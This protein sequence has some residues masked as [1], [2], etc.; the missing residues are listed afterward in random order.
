[1][2]TWV[3]LSLFAKGLTTGEISAHFEKISKASI[4]KDRIS[5]IT[6][7]VIDEMNEW[8]SR[9]PLP[10]YAAVSIDAIHA[11][12]R[13]GQVANRAFYAVIG[14]DLDGHRDVLGIWTGTDGRG[15]SAKYWMSVLTK[16]KTRGVADVLFIVGDGLKGILDSASAVF[17]LATIQTCTI[18]VIR[19]TFCATFADRM[20]AA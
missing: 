18:H 17:P 13:D 11:K 20:T 8:C 4:S 10:V 7:A 6:D 5:K 14:V 19:G 2:S 3:A 9:S 16:I 1:M 12:V 15:G